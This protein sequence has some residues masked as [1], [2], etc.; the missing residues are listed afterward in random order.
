MEGNTEARLGAR[1]KDGADLQGPE[2]RAASCGC[3]GL[4]SVV[5]L[6]GPKVK[7]SREL[8]VEPRSA[9]LPLVATSKQSAHSLSFC[10]KSMV[11][12]DI[13]LWIQSVNILEGPHE[14][15]Y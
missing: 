10:L 9:Q 15:K 14:V 12:Y 5:G 8:L 7:N 13:H 3:G 11:I 6:R 1:L 2:A 4:W